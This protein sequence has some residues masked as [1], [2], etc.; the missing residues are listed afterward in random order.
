MG[1]GAQAGSRLE[2]LQCG[3]RGEAQNPGSVARS[4]SSCKML[5]LHNAFVTETRPGNSERAEESS[6]FSKLPAASCMG[7]PAPSLPL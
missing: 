5:G 7:A 2:L 3:G 6:L 1:S 4:G